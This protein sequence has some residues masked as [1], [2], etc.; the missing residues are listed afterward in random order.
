M[1]ITLLNQVQIFLASSVFGVLLGLVYTIFWILKRTISASKIQDFMYDFVYLVVCAFLTFTFIF[2]FNYGEIRLYILAGEL[3]G[4]IVYYITVGS[5]MIK[6]ISAILS[7]LRRVKNKVKRIVFIPICSKLRKLGRK[8]RD[9]IFKSPHR[10]NNSKI[11]LKDRL[12][13]VY[14]SITRLKSGSK[15]NNGGIG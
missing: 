6:I 13:L 2:T 9:K 4:F 10:P 1:G 12:V 11:H 7:F 15:E 3:L 14:N 5:L 8:A